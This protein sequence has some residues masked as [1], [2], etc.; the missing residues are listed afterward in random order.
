M[1]QSRNEEVE[2]ENTLDPSDDNTNARALSTEGGKQYE[3]ETGKETT[4][5]LSAAAP[6]FNPST[7]P[8]FG[9]VTVPGFKDHGGLLPS[10]VNIPPML[11]VNPVRRSPHQSA[12]ARVPYGPRL[13]GGFNRSGN[14]VPRNKP[15][16]HNSEHT[17]DGDHFSPPRIMNPH[18]AEF[19]PGQTW[20]PNGYSMPQNGYIAI[21]NGMPVSPNG[22]PISPTSNPVS[23]NGYP[24]LLNG[25][26]AT[27]IGSPS[28]PVSSVE[29]PTLVS[30]DVGVENM[31]EAAAENGTETSAIEVGIEN[32]S[33]EK[34]LQEEDLNPEIE[35]KPAELP[36]TS[37]TVVAIETCDS[38]PI[39]EKPS[40]SWADYSDNEAEIVEVAS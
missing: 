28:S 31:S 19:M 27:Q 7:V 22:F 12:T 34:E 3:A 32:Q 14:R 5:K 30:V 18:A 9:S 37:D 25:I 29:T 16:F 33:G 10:P 26:Q 36:E 11:A 24:A 13:S 35:E 8:V 38:L 21:T 15:S 23:P 4:T 6:P 17:G 40:K 2:D 39:E 20:V 1:L